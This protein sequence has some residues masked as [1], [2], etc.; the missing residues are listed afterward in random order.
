MIFIAFGILLALVFIIGFNCGL[1]Y[2]NWL[3]SKR[4]WNEKEEK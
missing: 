4:R 3:V 2:D 1:L